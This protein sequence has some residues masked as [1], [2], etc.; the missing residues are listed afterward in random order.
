M[1]M[2]NIK[3]FGLW[4]FLMGFLGALGAGLGYLSAGGQAQ[5]ASVQSTLSF[6]STASREWS[7]QS[8]DLERM[9]DRL[10][11]WMIGSGVVALIGIGMY[12]AGGWE[13]GSDANLPA[14]RRNRACSC[15]HLQTLRIQAG[16]AAL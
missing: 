1:P 9:Q 6:G 16:V 12:F 10:I 14:V 13:F 3:T 5:H 4:L 15:R 8:R 2:M 11:P 7:M